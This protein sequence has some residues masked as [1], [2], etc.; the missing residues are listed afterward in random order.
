MKHLA[1]DTNAYRA[2]EEGNTTVA[3]AVRQATHIALP[4]IVLGELYFGFENG[5][6]KAKNTQQLDD[7]LANHRVEILHVDTATARIFGEV[8]TELLRAGKPIQQDDMWIASLCKQ[9]GYTLVT[10]D[11]G[12]QAIVG[13]DVVPFIAR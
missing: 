10:A 1:L 13:L 3:A 11:K 7:F 8:A 9:H 12:F 6:R 5:T 2:L 4:I